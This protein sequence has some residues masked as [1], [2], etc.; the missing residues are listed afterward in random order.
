MSIWNKIVSL[1]K[2]I[3]RGK[4]PTMTDSDHSRAIDELRLFHDYTRSESK[5]E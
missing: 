4:K 1:I 2:D 5:V 3:Y